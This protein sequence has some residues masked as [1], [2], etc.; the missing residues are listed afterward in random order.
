MNLFV[1]GADA[2]TQRVNDACISPLMRTRVIKDRE[3][4]ASKWQSNASMNYTCSLIDND[5]KHA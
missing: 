3:T 1:T 5:L 2:G 4:K